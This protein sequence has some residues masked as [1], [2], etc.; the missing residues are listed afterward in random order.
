MKKH[1][2]VPTKRRQGGFL[3]LNPQTKS[4]KVA[5]KST[6]VHMIHR[7]HRL[8]RVHK[9]HIQGSQVIFC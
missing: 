5:I 8:H 6:E 1:L 3:D 7:L 9:I 2:F 4:A